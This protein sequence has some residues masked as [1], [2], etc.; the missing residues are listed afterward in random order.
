MGGK[1][2]KMIVVKCWYATQCLIISIELIKKNKM[3]LVR[4][5]G[6]WKLFKALFKRHYLWATMNKSVDF[7][8]L[9]QRPASH[10]W[11][12]WLPWLP[13]SL[14][15]RLHFTGRSAV[16]VTPAASVATRLITA[17]VQSKYEVSTVSREKKKTNALKHKYRLMH[18]KHISLSRLGLSWISWYNRQSEIGT[19]HL[20]SYVNIS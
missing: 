18:N 5:K 16:T 17:I 8:S 15:A 12:C 4:F 7:R 6:Q 13:G 3:A 11:C 2:W 1:W 9:H 20:F 14:R 10:G 19:T